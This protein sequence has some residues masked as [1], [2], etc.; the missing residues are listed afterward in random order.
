MNTGRR[1]ALVPKSTGPRRQVR[2]SLLQ[3]VLKFAVANVVEKQA[4]PIRTRGFIDRMASLAPPALVA[5]RKDA[6]LGGVRCRWFSPHG[7][8]VD[9]TVIVHFHGGGFSMCSVK[10]THEFFLADY[11][12]LTRRRVLGVDYRKAPE[13]PFPIPIEDCLTVYKQLL[14][15]GYDP[16]KI[17]FSGDSAGGNLALAVGQRLRDEKLPMPRGMVLMSPW[18]DLELKGQTINKHEHSDYISRKALQGFAEAYLAGS[19]AADP[20]ASPCNADFTG[21]PPLFVQVGG[22]E[23]ML[24]EVRWMVCRAQSHGVD[25]HIEEWP[26][27]VHAFQ[28]FSVFLPDA[29]RALKS[30]GFYLDGAHRDHGRQLAMV[31]PLRLYAAE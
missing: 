29:K 5:R 3:K 1:L 8:T 10:N 24:S 20:L 30:V 18:V 28:G 2:L 13:H 4:S 16:Q 31:S 21:F 12:A 6:V 22:V 9:D 15:E 11:A 17:V 23:A 14:A 27:M 26:G 19:D 7:K 25:A